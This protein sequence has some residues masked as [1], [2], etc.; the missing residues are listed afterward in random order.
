MSTGSSTGAGASACSD[1]ETD[2]ISGYPSTPENAADRQDIRKSRKRKGT[3][4]KILLKCRCH[5]HWQKL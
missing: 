4:V 3:Y 1:K 5:P 2:S